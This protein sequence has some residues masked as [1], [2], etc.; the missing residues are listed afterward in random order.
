MG[1][2][3]SGLMAEIFIQYYEHLILKHIVKNR[4]ILFYTGCVDDIFMVYVE[5]KM[6][7]ND[8]SNAM[9]RFHINRS[10]SLTLEIGGQIQFF[11]LLNT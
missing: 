11:S 3:L 7:S 4:D 5:Y 9:N 8:L 1:T 10:F 2:A 6:N